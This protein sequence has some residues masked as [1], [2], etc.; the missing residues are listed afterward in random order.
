MWKAQN[1]QGI[2]IP[3]LEVEDPKTRKPIVIRNVGVDIIV[4]K[5]TLEEA[6]RTRPF[7]R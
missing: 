4:L 1:H 6:L 2:L 5:A 3:L 7:A